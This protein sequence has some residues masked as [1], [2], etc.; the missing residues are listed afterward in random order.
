MGVACVSR[1]SFQEFSKVITLLSLLHQMSVEV[2]FEN[3][4]RFDAGMV[5]NCILLKFLQSQLITMVTT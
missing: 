2:T 4:S 5:M 3:F 1:V